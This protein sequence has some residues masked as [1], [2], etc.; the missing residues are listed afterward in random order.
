MNVEAQFPRVAATIVGAVVGGVAA[1]GGT[2]P[3][4]S[5]DEAARPS[6]K[7]APERITARLDE[8][9]IGLDRDSAPSGRIA[10]KIRNDGRR[11]HEF[12]VLNSDDAEDALP[13]EANEVKEH[14]AGNLVDEAEDIRP[15]KTVTLGVGL[16]VPIVRS[17][18]PG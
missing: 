1:C 10:F 4:S 16:N 12:V 3:P 13:S 5:K 11:V 2:G 8:Y 14:A 15:R 7:G 9:A 17:P 6:P 18:S